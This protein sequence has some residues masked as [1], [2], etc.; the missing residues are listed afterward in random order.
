MKEFSLVVALLVCIFRCSAQDTFSIVAVDSVTH[1]VGSAGAS[2]IVIQPNGVRIISDVHPGVGAIHTQAYYIAGNQNH[3]KTYMNAGYSPQQI[4][5]SL[6]ANDVQGTASFRQYGVVDLVN[7]GRSATYTGTDCDDYK[8]HITGSYLSFT[9]SI[10]GNTLLGQGILDSIQ[11]RFVNTQGVLACRLMAALQGAKVIGADNRCIDDSV[12][13]LGSFLR[14]A[15]PGDTFG[16]LSLDLNVVSAPAGMDPIDSLQTKFN[17]TFACP[18]VGVQEIFSSPKLHVTPNPA[19]DFISIG[20]SSSMYRIEIFSV[21]GVKV[22]DQILHGV[23]KK[24]I[25]LTSV[26]DPI[27]LLQVTFTNGTK[28]TQLLIISR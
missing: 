13:S 16:T 17:A 19:A 1:E 11:S 20:S 5:D 7:G 9:Y 6:V 24:E 23:M 22:L 8:S 27:A 28:A 14:V 18:N 15:E 26:H 4:I 25:D 10:Q 2:C 3:G 12:S 21:T